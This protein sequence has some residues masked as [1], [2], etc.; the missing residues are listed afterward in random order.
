MR[1]KTYGINQLLSIGVKWLNKTPKM[2]VTDNTRL[3][4]ID[5]LQG[6]Y[7]KMPYNTGKKH[8]YY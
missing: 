3:I 5:M 7:T 8:P 2:K 1:I 6:N 4:V